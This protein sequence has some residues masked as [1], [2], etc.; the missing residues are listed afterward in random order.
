MQNKRILINNC[1]TIYISFTN[2][3][4]HK[5]NKKPAIKAGFLQEKKYMRKCKNMS[6]AYASYPLTVLYTYVY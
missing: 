2:A 1:Q 3:F 6:P 4:S 5:T